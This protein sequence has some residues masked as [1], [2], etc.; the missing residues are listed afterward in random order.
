LFSIIPISKIIPELQKKS[1][2]GI[3]GLF[4][5]GINGFVCPEY[6]LWPKEIWLT[7]FNYNEKT[8]WKQPNRLKN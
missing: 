2:S 4:Y 7:G 5:S 8:R 1:D 6:S 3:T